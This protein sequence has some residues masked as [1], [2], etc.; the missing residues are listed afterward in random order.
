MS[1]PHLDET[2]KPLFDLRGIQ[3]F[4]DFPEGPDWWSTDDYRAYVAQLAKMR[5]NFIGMHNYNGELLL[6]H[7]VAEDVN[8]DGTVKT[9]YPSKWFSNVNGGYNWGYAAD[10]DQRFHRRALRSCSHE[11]QCSPR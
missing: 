7:G 10:Q 6:W 1:C 9:T 4:H 8:P 5:M 2:G 11:T 3:P